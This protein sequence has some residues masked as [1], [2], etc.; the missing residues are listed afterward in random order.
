L[1]W[2]ERMRMR[3]RDWILV[4]LLIPFVAVLWTPFYATRQPEWQGV[5]FFIWYQFAWAILTASLT[6]VVYLVQQ[7]GKRP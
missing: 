3:A 2:V 1:G 6:I 5:P 7:S 4:L